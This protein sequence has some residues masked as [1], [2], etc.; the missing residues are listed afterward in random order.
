[1]DLARNAILWAID[2]RFLRERLSRYR[3]AGSGRASPSRDGLSEP[4]IGL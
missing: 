3:L 2:N 4:Q 1:M